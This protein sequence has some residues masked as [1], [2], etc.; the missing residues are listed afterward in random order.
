MTFEPSISN[1]AVKLHLRSRLEMPG[2]SQTS[3]RR[4]RLGNATKKHAE[5]AQHGAQVA[6]K[7]ERSSMRHSEPGITFTR[8]QRKKLAVYS[9][10]YPSRLEAWLD[11]PQVRL[12][13]TGIRNPRFSDAESPPP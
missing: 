6:L 8:S 2:D 9:V 12:Q 11:D 7:V 13:F 5:G 3:V 1:L 10:A 4:L